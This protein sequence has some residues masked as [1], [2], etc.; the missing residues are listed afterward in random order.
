MLVR[1]L[2]PWH[3]N[4]GKRLVRAPKVYVRDAGL[5]HAL[6]SIADKDTLLSHPVLGAS[7][8]SWV[9]E[10]L[11][12][13]APPDCEAFFY[14][15]AAGA[16]IDLLVQTPG[17]RA[18]G[19]RARAQL[20]PQARARLPLRLCRRAAHAQVAGVPRRRALS[21]R[22][23]CVGGVAGRVGPR[24]G[25]VV[26]RPMPAGRGSARGVAAAAS[27]RGD[28]LGRQAVVAFD[29]PR[30]FHGGEAAV[31]HDHTAV[32]DAVR[33]HAARGRRTARPAGRAARRRRRSSSSGTQTMSADMPGAS[34]PMSSRFSTCAPPSVAISS[35]SRARHRRGPL[36]GPCAT[37]CSSSARRASPSMWPLS[38]LAEPSTADR[39]RHA[40]IAHRADRRD[41]R[42]QP[43]VRARA[44][45]DAGAGARE[46]RDAGL[47][48]LDA[49]RVPDVAADP[50]EL[51]G[52]L[53]RRAAELLARVGDVVVVLGQVRVQRHAMLARQQRRIAHQLAAH[54]ERR[55][56]R[57]D[58]ALH[59]VA[60]AGRA[61]VRSGAACRVR[62]A[63][64]SSTTRVGRQ[65]ALRLADAHR[66]ACGMEAHADLRAPLRCC[67]RACTPFGIQVQVVAAGGAA[68]Q[69]QLGHRRLRR[70]EA[71][72]PASAR[73]RSGTAS[74]A[75]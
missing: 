72:S 11:L 41:A 50:A 75:S 12:A 7:W 68:R 44:V 67:R 14:R 28:Q 37:R 30:Q 54:R 34:A 46:Q 49:V 70:D 65:P 58:D 69:Q 1:R 19:H 18:L 60:R 13:L 74:S 31:A 59:R 16:E 52:V 43:H 33:A 32:D 20:E 27:G 3:A 6:L 5:L 36:T 38:L 57:D 29:Q 10:N 26:L 15:S 22:A 56:R 9:I 40:G 2:P 24:T 66:A 63:A 53:G 64:S 55:A 4:Q 62:I 39:H 17:R 61:S 45:R 8:E 35:A 51:L 73:P 23:G 21:H 48:E 25:V 42:G 71:P 47:V